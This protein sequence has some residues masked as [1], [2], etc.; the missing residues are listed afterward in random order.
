[1]RINPVCRL[2]RAAH[3]SFPPESLECFY[4][5]P[6]CRG[7]RL[8]NR[9]PAQKAEGADLLSDIDHISQF[10]GKVFQVSRSGHAALLVI[11]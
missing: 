9:F 10:S 4:E 7:H 3:Y 8:K 6:A 11:A 2:C 5:I 1:M